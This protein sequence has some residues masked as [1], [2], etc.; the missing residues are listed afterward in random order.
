MEDPL[1]QGVNGVANGTLATPAPS[2]VDPQTIIKYLSSVLQVTLGASEEDLKGPGSLL[3]EAQ[4][5]ETLSRCTRFAV[6]Q[7]P[8]YVL[9][10]AAPVQQNGYTNG[11]GSADT[12]IISSELNTSSRISGCVAFIKRSTNISNDAPISSQ[13]IVTNLPLPGASGLGDSSS[14]IPPYEHILSLMRSVITPCFEAAARGS[15][16]TSEKL[17]IDGDARTGVSG[18]RRKLADLEQSLESLQQNIEVEAPR[19]QVHESVRTQLEDA[20]G[21]L[22]AATLQIP[23]EIVSD[24]ALLNRL[25][26]Q[27]NDWIK[28]IRDF[29][30][31]TDDRMVGTTS[32]EKNFWL[33]MESAIESIEAQLASGGVQLTMKILEKAKRHG[34]TASFSSDTRLKE[35]KDKVQ[36]YNQL[37]HGFPIE[38]MLS[39]TSVEKLRDALDDVSESSATCRSNLC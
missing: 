19:L 38:E 14:A 37:F 17:R 25:Q 34:I 9:K 4:L 6:E 3:H 32:Q 29:T 35:T 23:N 26:N 28:Q 2:A 39:A 31:I 30:R 1:V 16:P 7:Q 13:L 33:A 10:Q 27:A 20:N 22:Q 8:L 36:R 18:A 12:Y 21:D 24:S 5:E 15:E 11:A